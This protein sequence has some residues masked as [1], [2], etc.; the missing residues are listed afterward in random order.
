MTVAIVTTEDITTDYSK[1]QSELKSST[2]KSPDLLRHRAVADSP[3]EV[4]S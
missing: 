3:V 2:V 4:N 1:E